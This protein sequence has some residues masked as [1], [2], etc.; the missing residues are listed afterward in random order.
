MS[1][2]VVGVAVLRAVATEAQTSADPE[3]LCV[4]PI[5]SE[6]S[7]LAVAV[8]AD[9]LPLKSTTAVMGAGAD[10]GGTVIACGAVDA[11]AIAT[12][13]L[14]CRESVLTSIRAIEATRIDEKVEKVDILV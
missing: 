14:A 9:D 13:T 6:S 7:D 2:S 3:Y 10:C 5:L 12:K 1:F 4:A 11:V 8:S